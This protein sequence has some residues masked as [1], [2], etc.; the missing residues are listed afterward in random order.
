[1]RVA[2][3]IMALPLL[4]VQAV[5]AQP[6]VDCNAIDHPAERLACYDRAAGRVPA[7]A[8]APAEA[9]P[10]A[11]SAAA[12]AQRPSPLDARWELT[13]ETRHETFKVRPYRGFYVMPA[14]YSSDRNE[15][16][17][18][19]GNEEGGRS[20]ATEPFELDDLE[21]AFQISF[22]TKL[23]HD[24]FGAPI[25]LWGGYT[26][27]SR[28]QVYNDDLSRPFR[29]TNYQPEFMMT[30]RTDYSFLGWE[31]SVLGL[32]L[33][34]QS[35]GRNDP[36]SRSWNRV[37][38]LA[39]FQKDDW[40]IELRPW[41]RLPDDKDEDDNPDITD[42]AGRAEALI[43]WRP[44][45]HYVALTGRHSMSLGN[46]RGSARLQWAFPLT[47]TLSGYTEIFSGYGDTLIDY[48]F[49]QT[50]YGIGIALTEW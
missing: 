12:P 21:A 18:S 33:N 13:P 45:R 37:I 28:W 31:L 35:N 44:G 15:A 19:D 50:T 25:D 30:A 48:N 10:P 17:C 39:A 34:H 8:P 5:R 26:Q 6:A 1:M 14:L 2:F 16:P 22:K 9:A 36:L 23:A 49:N 29:E 46:S 27:V 43:A 24:P 20:C 4:W 42:Y 47:G 32:S 11:R 38:G 3:L 41:Y 7:T 40:F